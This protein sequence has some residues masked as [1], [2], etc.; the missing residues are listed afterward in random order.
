MALIIC[1]HERSGTTLLRNLCHQHP[2]IAVTMELQCFGCTHVGFRTYA[3]FMTRVWQRNSSRSFLVQGE[4]ER[5]PLIV[6]RSHGFFARYLAQ[7]YRYSRA[8]GSVVDAT[9]I[10]RA[11]HAMFPEATVVGDK[12]P[13]YITR[14]P[15]LA[16]AEDLQVVALYRDCRAVVSSTLA[17][18]RGAWR[19]K[20]F[21]KQLDTAEKIARR[22]VESIEAIERHAAQV[23]PLRYEDFVTQPA[24]ELERL[25]AYIGVDPAGFAPTCIHDG[26]LGK[27]RE[28]LSPPQLDTIAQIAGS[29][30]DQLGYR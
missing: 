5:A 10:A 21:V 29:K 12:M 20:P 14:L 22:W 19:G 25:S 18:V 16:R 27:Y 30:L 11:L 2:A 28:T 1:G 7:V 9:T 24:R 15:I 13:A 6:L 3:R 17:Q 8:S 4:R 26:S 23:Y